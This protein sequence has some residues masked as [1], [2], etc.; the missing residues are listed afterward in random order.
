MRKRAR[1]A[2]DDVAPTVTLSLSSLDFVRL[3]CGRA[4]AEQIDAAGGIALEGEAA[5]GRQVLAAMNF[6]F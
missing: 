2:G 1:P 4:T 5:I 6:M 3:G